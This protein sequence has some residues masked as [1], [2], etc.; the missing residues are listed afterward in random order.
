VG[1]HPPVVTGGHVPSFAFAQATQGRGQS[2][3][4]A[5]THHPLL[6]RPLSPWPQHHAPRQRHR[7]GCTHAPI[8]WSKGGEQ[9][10]RVI[11]G[12]AVWFAL[13]A[14]SA[15]SLGDMEKAKGMLSGGHRCQDWDTRGSGPHARA[16]TRTHAHARAW[17]LHQRQP[18][19]MERG[20]VHT[21]HHRTPVAQ[22]GVRQAP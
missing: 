21:R 19:R 17:W 22:R 6:P 12:P 13:R 9:P 10:R 3:S 8:R 4:A 5:R 14:L 11:S 1:G 18:R 7:D 2:S 16:R 20:G 15:G